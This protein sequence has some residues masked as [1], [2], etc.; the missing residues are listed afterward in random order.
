MLTASEMAQWLGVCKDTILIW[1]RNGLLKA[2]AY[3]DKNQRLYQ[4]PGPDAP[5]KGLGRK[6]TE[7]RRFPQVTSD[8][9]KEVQ[10][11]A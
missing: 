1:R 2:H 9:S 11:E 10:Y 4:P 3:N 8:R 7:R 5:V 6:L